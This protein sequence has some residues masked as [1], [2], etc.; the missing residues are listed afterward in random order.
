ML[1]DATSNNDRFPTQNTFQIDGHVYF[2]SVIRFCEAGTPRRGFGSA[3]NGI[4]AP[5]CST[6]CEA[7]LTFVVQCAHYP[8]LWWMRS[9][10]QSLNDRGG[11]RN[12]S[13][14]R[15]ARGLCQSPRLTWG[16]VRW[17]GS[18]PSFFRPTPCR[19][20]CWS[21]WGHLSEFPQQIGLTQ[22]WKACDV[23]PWSVGLALVMCC[24][25]VELL[26]R[27]VYLYGLG[28]G[29]VGLPSLVRWS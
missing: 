5:W 21:C 4:S 12:M 27:P 9:A 8:I 19:S 1:R 6:V 2:V 29:M 18:G 24:K 15:G 16:L 20:R 13:W 26:V 22:F 11:L 17:S 14:C 25:G 7:S 28:A 10:H 23:V 3:L